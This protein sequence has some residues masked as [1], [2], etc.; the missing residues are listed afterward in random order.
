[1]DLDTF[2]ITVFCWV[3]EMLKKFFPHQ[4]LRQRGP[5]P[6]LADSEVCTIEI[7]GEYLGLDQDKKIYRYFRRHYGHFFPALKKVHRTT[8]IRQ[9][10]NLWWVK[11]MLW[12]HLLTLLSYDLTLALVDS[13]PLP[14]CQFARAYRCRRFKGE[15]AFGKDVL[16]RQTFYG[17]RLH[18]RACWPG[19]IT[20][21]TIAPAN[22]H[23]T[24]VAPALAEG[25]HGLL[26][27][28]RN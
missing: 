11:K 23:E 12:Q 27:G 10:S 28:D 8:F 5:E 20:S 14:V 18:A 13:L 19:A 22:I 15:A 1:M 25:T 24:A 17:F 7:V 3:D 4:R 26:I 6:T 21:F 9:A 16:T 2:I